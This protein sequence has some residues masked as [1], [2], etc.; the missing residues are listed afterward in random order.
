[1]L[2]A[3]S[4]HFNIR[5]NYVNVVWITFASRKKNSRQTIFWQNI[6]DLTFNIDYIVNLVN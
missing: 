4:Y 2:I 6:Y 5:S 1:M 3:H